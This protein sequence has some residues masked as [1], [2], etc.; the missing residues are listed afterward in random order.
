[1]NVWRKEVHEV[2]RLLAVCTF[3]IFQQIDDVLDVPAVAKTVFLRYLRNM[4]MDQRMRAIRIS[5]S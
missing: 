3:Q 4:F 2:E 1:M 5:G